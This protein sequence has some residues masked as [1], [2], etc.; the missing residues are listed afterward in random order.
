MVRV[1]SRGPYSVY[2]Y[3]EEDQPHHLAHCEVRWP[4]HSTQVDLEELDVIVGE[5][6]PRRALEVVRDHLEEIRAIWNRLNPRR[7]LR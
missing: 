3:M 2:V 4:G 1:V 7:P 5:P 6:I